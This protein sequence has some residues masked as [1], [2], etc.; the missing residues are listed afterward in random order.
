LHFNNEYLANKVIINPQYIVDVM[1]CLVSLNND[2][3]T[4]G[5]LYHSKVPYIWSKYDASLHE[6]ILK[7]TEKFD[8]TFEIERKQMNLVP[9]LMADTSL[10]PIDWASIKATDNEKHSRNKDITVFYSFDYLPIGLFNRIQVRLYQISNNELI[11]KNGSLLEKNY[12]YALIQKAGNKIEIRVK[13][14]KKIL[15]GY[16]EHL[17]LISFDLATE[18]DKIC[19]LNFFRSHFR[20]NLVHNLHES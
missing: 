9:C 12:H 1:S 8:L 19:L 17:F 7:L 13:G 11:W 15:L 10:K 20:Q 6:W 5:E 2:H 4:N 3:I 14:K 18:K 16:F